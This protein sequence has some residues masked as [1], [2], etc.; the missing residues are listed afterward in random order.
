MS[1]ANVDID[2]LASLVA[3]GSMTLEQAER[4]DE[5]D[6]NATTLEEARACN[7]WNHA[8]NS[9]VEIHNSFSCAVQRA[10][11]DTQMRLR[12]LRATDMYQVTISQYF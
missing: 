3:N 2:S 12:E 9:S 10:I 7:W 11:R 5:Y 6:G 4:T 8:G 1:T